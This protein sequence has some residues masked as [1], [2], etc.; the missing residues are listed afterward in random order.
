MTW[1]ASRRKHYEKEETWNPWNI[2]ADL[3]EHYD[4]FC[5]YH[6]IHRIDGC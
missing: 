6:C 1:V 3:H 2:N 5:V 4:R